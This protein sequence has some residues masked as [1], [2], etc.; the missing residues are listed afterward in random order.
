MARGKEVDRDMVA[1]VL[2]MKARNPKLTT[3]QIGAVTNCDA[4]TAGKI[5]KCGSWEGYCEFRK[6]KARKQQ[7]RARKA[8]EEQ[9]AEEQV[10]GQITM[11]LDPE[12]EILDQKPVMSDQV[13]M[14]RFQAVQ[15]DKI[16]AKICEN[17]K[18]VLKSLEA[19]GYK[20]DR[21]YDLMGQILR[22]IRKD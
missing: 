9:P 3:E 2:Q 19:M 11:Q 7:E 12:E 6:E 16:I 17:N 13:K 8:A 14:M 18:Q 20:I 10:P 4:S 22:A 1:L 15:A 21:A 5:I